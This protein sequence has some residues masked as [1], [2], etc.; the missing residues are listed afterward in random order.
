GASTNERTTWRAVGKPMKTQIAVAVAGI[1][2]CASAHAEIVPITWDGFVSSF[3]VENLPSFGLGVG[4]PASG[5]LLYDPFAFDQAPIIP[6]YGLYF[7]PPDFFT[8][9]VSGQQWRGTSG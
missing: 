5:V 7:M 6:N 1:L 3:T 4:P 8:A 9:T 2:T